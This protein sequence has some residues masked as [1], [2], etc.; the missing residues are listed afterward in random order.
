[1]GLAWLEFVE[2][3]LKTGRT[4]MIWEPNGTVTDTSSLGDLRPEEV[5]FEFEEPLTFT[6][7]D[8]DGQMLLAHNLCAEGGISRYL[9]VATD[10]GIVDRLKAERLDMLAALRQP[11]WC[12]VDFGPGCEIQRLWHVPFAEI[13]TTML[14]EA[15]ATLAM[16]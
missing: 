11:S 6:C 5:L 1:M 16:E 13:P 8:R 3:A 12:I 7:R 14:P 2:I 9:L 15:N 10:Q 4:A